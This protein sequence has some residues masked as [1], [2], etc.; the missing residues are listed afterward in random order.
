MRSKLATLHGMH[1]TLAQDQFTSDILSSFPDVR[2]ADFY[3]DYTDHGGWTIDLDALWDGEGVEIDRGESGDD[4]I[5]ITSSIYGYGVDVIFDSPERGEMSLDFVPSDEVRFSS[6]DRA[7][8]KDDEQLLTTENVIEIKKQLTSA[9]EKEAAKNLAADLR[10]V[11]PAIEG[12]GYSVYPNEGGWMGGYTISINDLIIGGK[13]ISRLDHK[14]ADNIEK[15]LMQTSEYDL[16]HE[17]G[18]W[19]DRTL[20]F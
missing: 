10:A 6:S 20:M 16:D 11:D 13:A 2:R 17:E 3:L 8:F 12:V 4:D 18:N 15:A 5:M 7:L 9:I 14:D 19:G 1:A